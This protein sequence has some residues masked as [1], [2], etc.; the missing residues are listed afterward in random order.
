MAFE[1]AGFAARAAAL[2]G[3]QVK[4]RQ[5]IYIANF[6]LPTTVQYYEATNE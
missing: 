4:R 5:R 1:L 3:S 6:Q 2:S